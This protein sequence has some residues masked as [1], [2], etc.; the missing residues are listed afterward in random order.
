[1]VTVQNILKVNRYLKITLGVVHD[2][3]LHISGQGTHDGTGML[4]PGHTQSSHTY[5]EKPNHF[6]TVVL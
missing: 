6:V 4:G 3:A 1:M 2:T 5:Y